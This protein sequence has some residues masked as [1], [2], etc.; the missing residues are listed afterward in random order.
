MEG[1]Y[2][3]HCTMYDYIVITL[4]EICQPIIDERF[5]PNR[6]GMVLGQQSKGDGQWVTEHYDGSISYI[7]SSLIQERST[8][9]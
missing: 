8:S 1:E 3:N 5:Y 9:L 6:G 2:S 7:I 4:N